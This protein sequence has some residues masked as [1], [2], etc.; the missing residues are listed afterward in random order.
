GAFDSPDEAKRRDVV[1]VAH[2]KVGQDTRAVL[3]IA[4]LSV[5]GLLRASLFAKAT[6]ILTSATLTVGG[7]FDALAATWGLPA[8]GRRD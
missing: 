7:N 6:V 8:A 5:G 4:P 1:W 3:R 2:D